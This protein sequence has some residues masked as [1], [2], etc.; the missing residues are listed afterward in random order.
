MPAGSGSVGNPLLIPAIALLILSTLFVMLIVLS[1]PGQIVRIRA[2]DT[3]TSEGT[4]ELL[5]SILFLAMWTISNLAVA[6]GAISM[7]RLKSYRSAYSAAI[8]SILPLCSPCFVLGIPFGIW[9][10]VV[11]Y[12][13]GVKQRFTAK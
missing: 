5:G 4:G 3:S 10:L 12:R 1:L 2:I 8:L 11:L 6:Q 7:L 13:P 9:A